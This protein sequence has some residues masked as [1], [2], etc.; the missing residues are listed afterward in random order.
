MTFKLGK[1]NSKLVRVDK[2]IWGKCEKLMPGMTNPARSKV[3]FNFSLLNVES[4]LRS[5]EKRLNE[6]KK[7]K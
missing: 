7:K 3:L 2:S 6:A 5:F 4:S 1:T